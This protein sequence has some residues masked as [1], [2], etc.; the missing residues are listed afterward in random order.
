MTTRNTSAARIALVAAFLVLALAL[1][2]VALA[3]KGHGGSS[4]GTT[5]GGTYS[6]TISPAGPYVFGEQVYVTTNAPV[7]P[8][9]GGPWIA[10]ACYQNGVLVGNA[11]HS[12][13]PGGWYY[14]WPFSL[15]P[16]LS[17]SSGAAD[18]TFTV[19]YQ[20][21]KKSTIVASTTIHVNA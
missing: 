18:C 7:D 10:M 21:S 2:P 9:G 14:G 15:G 17:W 5:S 16:S 12:G 11:T 13:F 1:V 8:N 4:G 6:I 20:T 19:G 3:A